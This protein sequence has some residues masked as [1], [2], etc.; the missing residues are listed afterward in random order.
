ML[1]L[2]VRVTNH[3]VVIICVPVYPV[4]LTLLD[5]HQDLD[6]MDVNAIQIMEMVIVLL[7]RL[8][9]VRITE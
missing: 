3:I 1:I 4:V 8:A 5:H 6:V 7:A 2:I 9:F